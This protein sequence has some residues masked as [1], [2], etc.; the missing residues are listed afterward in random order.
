VVIPDTSSDNEDQEKIVKSSDDINE[1]SGKLE[2]QSEEDK[3]MKSVLES[4]E[5]TI[6][7]GRLLA[8]AITQGVGF[9]TPDIMFENLVKDYKTAK[10]LYGEVIIRELTGYS[11]DYVK[12]NINIPEFKKEMNKKIRENIEDLKQKGLV[13]KEGKISDKGFL[14][15]SIVLYTEELDHL[16]PKGF[17]EKEKKEK[18]VYGEKGEVVD[19]KKTRYRDLAIRKSIKNALRRGHRDLKKEDL[20]VFERKGRGKISII[21]GIDASGSMK[22]LKLKTAKKAGIALSFKA[23]NE[24]NKVGLL[25]F[26]SEIKK[27]VEP[28]NDFLHILKKLSEISASKETDIS[29]TIL[30]AL[31]LFPKKETKHL[32]LLTD[33]IPTKGESPEKQTLEAASL[34]RDQ[35]VTISVIGI[36]L[37]KEGAKLAEKIVEIGQG[38]LY[39]VRDLENLDSVVLEDYGMVKG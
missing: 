19:Y 28:T 11:S 13:D 9:F 2:T 32:V 16:L 39:R 21:Y 15:S 30:R 33:A 6:N 5:E 14:L 29:K 18:S 12:K 31:E 23:I 10:N 7:D 37:E 8:D 3:L 24:K 35:G 38:R 1:Y 34:A 36:N 26:G 22:G 20:K 25:V 17:G 4:E 27:S